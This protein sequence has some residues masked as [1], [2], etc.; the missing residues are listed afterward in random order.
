M[1][2]NETG[3]KI[4]ETVKVDY[5]DCSS[6]YGK[7]FQN[8]IAVAEGKVNIAFNT[9]FPIKLREKTD[10]YNIQYIMAPMDEKKEE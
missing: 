3:D 9:F 4:T 6:K 2:K 7:L 5:R 1:L 10:K 8:I